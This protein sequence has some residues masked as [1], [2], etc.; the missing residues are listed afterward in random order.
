MHRLVYLAPIAFAVLH[1]AIIS[2]MLIELFL[3]LLYCAQVFLKVIIESHMTAGNNDWGDI[4]T[5]I[6]LYTDY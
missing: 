1:E 4:Y 6:A 3:S 5:T 2:F